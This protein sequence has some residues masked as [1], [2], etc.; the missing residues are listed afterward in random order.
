MASHVFATDIPQ[1][2]PKGM[3]DTACAKT[4]AGET[5]ADEVMAYCEAEGLPYRKVDESEPFRFGPGAK[6]WSEYDLIIPILWSSTTLLLRVSVVAKEVP[7]LISR[8]VMKRLGG[9]VDFMND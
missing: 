3:I 5:W 9:V 2:G 7:C 6:I 1:Q 8:P 4:V